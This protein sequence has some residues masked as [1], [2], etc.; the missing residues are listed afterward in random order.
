[1]AVSLVRVKC[2]EQEDSEPP[3]FDTEDDE[4]YVIV[5]TVNGQG[6]FLGIPG[7]G[8]QLAESRLFRIGPMEGF[9]KGDV[10]TPPD[11]LLWGLN[12]TPAT[13]A[14]IDQLVFLVA[15][16]ENDNAN[17]SEV[18]NRMVT[19]GQAGLAGLNIAAE[20]RTDLDPQARFELFVST[21]R[22][23]FDGAADL[24]RLDVFDP[25]DKIGPVQVLRFFDQEQQAV[26]RNEIPAFERTLRFQGDDA[27]YELTF[28][29]RR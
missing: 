1:M 17:P 10:K 24:A 16:F 9:D 25:D 15:L 28:A 20:G 18:E 11:N 26:L 3:I 13:I 21:A 7:N 19:T 2:I 6:R 23:S 14:R 27:D 12:D 4:P 8:I 29:L 22:Q 5:L